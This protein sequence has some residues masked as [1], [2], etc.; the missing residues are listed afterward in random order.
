MNS[1]SLSDGKKRDVKSMNERRRGWEGR[2]G[3]RLEADIVE[4]VVGLSF[5]S[6]WTMGDVGQDSEHPTIHLAATRML[7]RKPRDGLEL[8][9][10]GRKMVSRCRV[11]AQAGEMHRSA[12]TNRKSRFG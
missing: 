6:F 2:C 5:L 9:P 4:M 12:P 8:A 11:V 7:P 3:R 1:E 10:K